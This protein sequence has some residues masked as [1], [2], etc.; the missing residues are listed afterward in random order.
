MRFSLA[1]LATLLMA[2]VA[3]AAPSPAG[4]SSSPANPVDKPADES[5]SDPGGHDQYDSHHGKHDD[6]DPHHGKHDDHDHDVYIDKLNYVTNNYYCIDD[7]HLLDL[8]LLSSGDE[9]ARGALLDLGLL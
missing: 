2:G 7:H 5:H 1:A 9:C 3:F 4:D 8:S 6:H